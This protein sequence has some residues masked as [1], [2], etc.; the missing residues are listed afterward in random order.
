MNEIALPHYT[1][2]LSV[3]GSAFRNMS[4]FSNGRTCVVDPREAG[5]VADQG[6]IVAR[7]DLGL[8]HSKIGYSEKRFRKIDGVGNGGFR[9]IKMAF[10]KSQN[11]SILGKAWILRE[12]NH[13]LFSLSAEFWCPHLF[14]HNAGHSDQR[15]LS[16]FI[17]HRERIA[18]GMVSGSR[19]KDEIEKQVVV[20]LVS[21]R[22]VGKFPLPEI[23]KKLFPDLLLQPVPKRCAVEI[24]CGCVFLNDVINVKLELSVHLVEKTDRIGRYKK[25]VLVYLADLYKGVVGLPRR[26]VKK[27]F[28]GTSDKALANRHGDHER[29]VK[30]LRFNIIE[31]RES[32]E[33]QSCIFLARHNRG[34]IRH[35]SFQNN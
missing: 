21:L 26:I 35:V 9:D 10:V 30:T 34:K 20:C 1:R 17:E 5:L 25:R 16:S 14:A 12:I 22:P 29:A 3:K 31:K 33:D 24:M 15:H 7:A 18:A 4:L 23:G 2:I 28:V 6:T 11:G 19:I 32:K 27:P 8:R 13:H